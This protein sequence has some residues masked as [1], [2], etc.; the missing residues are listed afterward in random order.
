MP[1]VVKILGILV[2]IVGVIFT[3]TGAV[4]VGATAALFGLPF[5]AGGAAFACL[6]MIASELA[7]LREISQQQ[8][9]LF[10]GMRESRRS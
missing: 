4:G 2:F 10:K 9:E 1:E 7:S 5:I 6:G 8:L 3:I